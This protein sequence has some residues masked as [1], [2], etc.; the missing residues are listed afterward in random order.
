M[1]KIPIKGGAFALV[2]DDCFDVLSKKKWYINKGKNTSY[3]STSVWDEGTN[4]TILMHTLIINIPNGLFCD[5]INGD[6]LDN[7]RENLRFCTNSQNQGNSR[8]PKNNT[9]GFKGVTFSK[10]HNK[11]QAQI[12]FNYKNIFLGRFEDKR[13]AAIAYNESAKNYFGEFAKLNKI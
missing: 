5:H 12:K 7:R 10:R 9:S 2:D 1:K 4:R 11:W 3:A 8:M 13:D 6:G